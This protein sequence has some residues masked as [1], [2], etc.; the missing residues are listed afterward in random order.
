MQCEH[1]AAMVAEKIRSKIEQTP[2]IYNGKKIKVTVS[3]GVSVAEELSGRTIHDMVEIADMA[4]YT[5]KNHGK[6]QVTVT[7]VKEQID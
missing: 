5:S 2:V 1:D 6:N 7:K 3:V 4:M